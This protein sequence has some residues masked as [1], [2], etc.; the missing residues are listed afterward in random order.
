MAAVVAGTSF[1]L[2]RHLNWV[3]R[4]IFISKCD[5]ES[6]EEWGVVFGLPRNK[7]TK[8]FGNIRITGDNGFRIDKGSELKFS[9]D[10]LSFFTEDDI[11]IENGFAIVSVEAEFIGSSYNLPDQTELQFVN[12]LPR[13][14]SRATV[15]AEGI[16]N[17][18]PLEDK[19]DYRSRLLEYVR[20]QSSGGSYADYINWAK[21]TPGVSRAW[22][23]K[24]W[25]GPA[26]VAICCQESGRSLSEGISSQLKQAVLATF[27]V[28]APV[29]SR[30]RI[31]DIQPLDIRLTIRIK[32]NTTALRNE[33]YALINDFF[34]NKFEP[35][36]FR[37]ADASTVPNQLTGLSIRDLFFSGA[38][39]GLE[40]I[41][42]EPLGP[43]DTIDLDRAQIPIVRTGGITFTDA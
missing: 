16:G 9:R 21:S 13:I 34:T 25:S 1:I 20:S 7:G 39:S 41:V 29:I 43:S 35:A 6:L 19:E 8:A 37:R 40:R 14:A 30:T 10:G 24:E 27:D 28:K 18:T 4:Q 15:E 42:V 2:H 11:S 38:I 26:S 36:G 5:E 3:Y 32:P 17:G 23:F 33:V 31:V 12:P 22:V